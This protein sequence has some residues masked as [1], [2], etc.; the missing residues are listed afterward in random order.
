MQRTMIDMY[1]YKIF[2]ARSDSTANMNA[3]LEELSKEGWEPVQ[4]SNGSVLA[5][6]TK[7]KTLND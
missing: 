5:R 2:K 7:T 1:E 3:L 4:V 6:R